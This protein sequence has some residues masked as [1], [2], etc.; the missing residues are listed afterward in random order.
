MIVIRFLLKALLAPVLLVMTAMT[1]LMGLVLA[2]STRVLALVSSLFMF[3]ALLVFLIG[4][5][6]DGTVLLILA[7]AV[8]P[9]GL[10]WIAEYCWKGVDNLRGIMW[11][12]VF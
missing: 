4:N 8:S 2:I 7:W 10:P 3:L 11:R 5:W 6:R 9:Y 1:F 12:L